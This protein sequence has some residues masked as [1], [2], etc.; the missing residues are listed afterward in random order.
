MAYGKYKHAVDFPK[1]SFSM[2]ANS[3]NREPEIQKLWDDNQVFKRV[4]DKN[5]GVSV[6]APSIYRTEM[7]FC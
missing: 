2:R 1:T 5:N 4:V 3:V 6:N 7:H